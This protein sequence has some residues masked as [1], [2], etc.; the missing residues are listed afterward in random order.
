MNES[1]KA[2]LEPAD[3]ELLRSDVEALK[4]AIEGLVD[5]SQG[6][7]VD[8]V[9]EAGRRL[10]GRLAEGGERSV[11]AVRETVEDRPLTSIL[12]AFIIG[13]IGGRYLVR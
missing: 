12:V 6:G 13:F 3:F 5:H 4:A 9:N 11:N 8:K 7:P 2:R 1:S 10:Y